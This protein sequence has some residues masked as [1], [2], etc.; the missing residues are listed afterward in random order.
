MSGLDDSSIISGQDIKK[1]NKTDVHSTWQTNHLNVPL[2]T[3]VAIVTSAE[4]FNKRYG[5]YSNDLNVM[6]HSMQNK[7]SCRCFCFISVISFLNLLLL[8]PF[9][10]NNDHTR[11]L[12]EYRKVEKVIVLV[13]G[14]LN[15]DLGLSYR[16]L[17]V[18]MFVSGARSQ[19]YNFCIWNDPSQLKQCDHSVN[20]IIL[21][22]L[23][24]ASTS[25]VSEWSYQ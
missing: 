17:Q 15:P 24:C 12:C 9:Q 8:L 16:P 10:L 18:F 3:I 21:I 22:L 2:C 19:Q 23:T 13:L 25:T 6:K 1:N 11:F 7:F 20:E 4:I 5:L 14:L